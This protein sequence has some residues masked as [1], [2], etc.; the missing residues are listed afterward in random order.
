MDNNQL[1]P[2]ERNRYYSG[3]MLT[4]ADFQAEQLYFNNKRRFINNIM[5]GSGIVCGCEVFNLDDL[6]VIIESGVA[7]DGLGREIVVDSSV[8]K[9]LSAIDG[10]E[11]L[12][13]NNISLCLQYAEQQVHSVYAVNQKVNEKEYEYNRISE[14]YR[15]FV[16][17]T[18]ALPPEF[19]MEDEFLSRGVLYEDENYMIEIISPETVCKGRNVKAQLK[20]TK[21]SA[22]ECMISY[23]GIIQ[24]PAYITPSGEHEFEIGFTNVNL[25]EGETFV[26]DYWFKV[27]D[28]PAIDTNLILKSGSAVVSIDGREFPASTGFSMKILISS[29]SPRDLISRQLGRMSLEMKNLGGVQDYIRLADIRLVHTDS[30]YVIEEVIESDV[31]KY[32]TSPADELNRERYMEYFLKEADIAEAE[33]MA[34]TAPS[35]APAAAAPAAEIPEVASGSFEI[36]LGADASAGSVFYSGEIMHSLG[37]GNV[38]VDV[39]FEYIVEDRALGAR[40]R[41]TIY[42]ASELF[43]NSEVKA[44]KVTTAVKVNN[45]K[46]SFTVAARLEEDAEYLILSGRWVAMR[47]PSGSKLEMAEDN[48]GKSIQAETPTVVIAS[49]ESHYFGVKFVNMEES[50]LTYELTEPNSGEISSDGIYTAPASEGVY[51]IRIS[52]SDAPSIC[53]Y[54]YAIVKKNGF[55]DEE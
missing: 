28:V 4:S 33:I 47:F 14:G 10:F 11:K 6:S 41:T 21:L 24:A 29:R 31:K 34:A 44:A 20:V 2:F 23:R 22:D 27:A 1:Y 48:T 35:A 15:I 16:A 53:T 43:N 25:T 12:R 36:P 52:C 5:Y 42:G 51:E 8:V 26:K 37:K 9:K 50:S 18:E 39:G 46:G 49:K 38:Y 40:A 30:A 32:I 3:K 45:D 7:I 13:T 54:A 17:D 55:E 19:D